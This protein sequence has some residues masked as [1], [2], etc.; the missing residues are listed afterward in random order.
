MAHRRFML[1]DGLL[2]DRDGH[3]L[4]RLVSVVLDVDEDA[5]AA[6]PSAEGKGG[7]RGVGVPSPQ[8][9]SLS[10][11]VDEAPTAG[12]GTG[13][14]SPIEAVWTHYVEVMAP[15]NRE[16]DPESRK[17]IREALK[18]ATVDECR[19][20]IDGNK[21]SDWHQGQNDRRR[22]YNKLGQILK[23]RPRQNETTRDRID[24][25][26]DLAEKADEARVVSSADR[27]KVRAAKQAV[28]AAFEY[29]GDA[30]VVSSGEEASRWLRG[31]GWQINPGAAGRPIFRAP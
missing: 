7:Y 12:G 18:V 23:G 6:P 10:S 17:I 5:F 16:L 25:F 4:G 1:K 29:P 2:V 11:D 24:F 21:A 22:K 8:Q 13:E 27:G 26:L 9:T 30:Q 15:R 19:R 20:A 31:Q 28:L 14:G 3:V